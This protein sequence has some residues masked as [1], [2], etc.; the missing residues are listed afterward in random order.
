MRSVT[1]M[2]LFLL[3]TISVFSQKKARTSPDWTTLEEAEKKLKNNNIPVLIDLYTDWCGWCKVMDRKTW[4]DP[5]VRSYLQANFTPVKINAESPKSIVWNNE[6]YRWQPNQR[7]HEFALFIAGPRLSYPTLVI[8]PAAGEAPQAIPGYLK[9]RELEPILKYF[10]E[11]HW[12]KID[13]PTFH[14]TFNSSW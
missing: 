10:G 5:Q 12:K 3:C 1:L 2:V 11:G 9:P 14:K 8:I 7:T 6:Q 13:F 4:S